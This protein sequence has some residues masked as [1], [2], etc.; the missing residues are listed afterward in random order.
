[1]TVL[2]ILIFIMLLLLMCTL[3]A[4]GG[5]IFAVNK[6]IAKPIKKHESD[7]VSVRKAQHEYNNFLNYRGDEMPEFKL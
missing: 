3:C 5:Y 2:L 7:S 1:L 6:K 4:L